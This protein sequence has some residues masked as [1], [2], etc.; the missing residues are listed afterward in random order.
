MTLGVTRDLP[1][2]SALLNLGGKIQV[3]GPEYSPVDKATNRIFL[4]KKGPIKKR[5]QKTEEQR[6]AYIE[7]R[8]QK[9]R[10]S[11]KRSRDREKQSKKELEEELVK[12]KFKINAM[13]EQIKNCPICRYQMSKEWSNS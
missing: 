6:A 11:A 9:N 2:C 8:K 1:V 12:L 5:N 13:I 7:T 10:L 4:E 3:D